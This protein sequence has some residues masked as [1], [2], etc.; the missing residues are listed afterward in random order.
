MVNFFDRSSNTLV[1]YQSHDQMGHKAFEKL[2]KDPDVS[3]EKYNP[4]DYQ[5]LGPKYLTK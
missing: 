1:T 3:V 2:R 4:D 5:L